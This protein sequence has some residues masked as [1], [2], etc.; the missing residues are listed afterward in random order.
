MI[1][2]WERARGG[3][4]ACPCGTF[5]ALCQAEN[6]C[7]KDLRNLEGFSAVPKDRPRSVVA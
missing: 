7:S 2:S 3:T 5:F 6:A 4:Y 1:A